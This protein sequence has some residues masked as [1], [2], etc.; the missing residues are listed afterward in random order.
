MNILEIC[1]V[2]WQRS[3]LWWWMFLTRACLAE[4]DIHNIEIL[5]FLQGKPAWHHFQTEIFWEWYYGWFFERKLPGDFWK[6][7]SRKNIG[8]KMNL[9]QF[10]ENS[11]L[12]KRVWREPAYT[13]RMRG[14]NSTKI[15]WTCFI[16]RTCLV[17]DV[18][19]NHSRPWRWQRWGWRTFLWRGTFLEMKIYPMLI[20]CEPCRGFGLGL[21]LEFGNPKG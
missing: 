6:D 8:T 9:Y 21:D 18:V 11:D 12:F 20:K 19:R 10:S 16:C 17:V 14:I 13:W 3:L 2:Q 1:L 5:G 4:S 7:H 15:H